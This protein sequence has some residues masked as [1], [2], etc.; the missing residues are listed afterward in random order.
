M[1]QVW[2]TSLKV[3][4]SLSG[5]DNCKQSTPGRAA[6]QESCE[7][8]RHTASSR[9]SEQSLVL[10]RTS[11]GKIVRSAVCFRRCCALPC[12]ALPSRCTGVAHLEFSMLGEGKNNNKKSQ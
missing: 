8:Q 1:Q 6:K 11:S 4:H 7:A 9:S 2:G 12:C 10:L 3:A 5:K